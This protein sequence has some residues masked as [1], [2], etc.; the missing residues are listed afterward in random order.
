MMCCRFLRGRT[1]RFLTVLWFALAALPAGAAEPGAAPPTT[2]IEI[3]AERVVENFR[4][5]IVLHD[6]S[7][8][9]RTPAAGLAGRVLFYRNRE[10]T[11]QLVDALTRAS[12]EE[13]AARVE[14]L[15]ALFTTH[16]DWWD[17]DR[18]ALLGVVNETR[19]R[20]PA[21]DALTQRVDRKRDE[22]SLIRAAYNNEFTAAL[23]ARAPGA[24]GGPRR[25][26]WDGYLASLRERYPR[27]IGRA[28]V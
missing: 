14:R 3:A 21:G 12:R 6:G 19:L 24:A 20:L 5:L 9:T 27:E 17:I 1:A 22:I 25:A 13:N 8:R 18:I 2:E 11:A 15:L 16:T 23:A 28:H 4:K 26:G 7:A 10:L